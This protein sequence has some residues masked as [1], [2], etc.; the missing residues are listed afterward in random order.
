MRAT[1]CAAIAL[2]KPR[3]PRRSPRARA[4][5]QPQDEAQQR[6][7]EHDQTP[8][9]L[10]PGRGRGIDGRDDRPEREGEDDDAAETG[11]LCHGGVL[12]LRGPR[13]AGLG[14]GAIGVRF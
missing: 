3:I 8:D 4:E 13:V 14:V 10:A 6:Q 2:E 11:E 5:E 7:E 1:I 12:A 9:H